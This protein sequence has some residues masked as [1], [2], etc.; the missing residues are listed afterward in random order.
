MNLID[1][2]LFA[3]LSPSALN[4]ILGRMAARSYTTNQ[5]ICREGTPPT[6]CTYSKAVWSKSLLAKVQTL[7]SLPTCVGEISLGRWGFS[8][9]SHAQRAS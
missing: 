6:A 4:D 9:M 2:P 5:Y 1:S 3:G 8:V 7:K